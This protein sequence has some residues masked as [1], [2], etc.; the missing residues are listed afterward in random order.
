MA[1]LWERATIGPHG[2]YADRPLPATVATACACAAAWLPAPWWACRGPTEQMNGGRRQGRPPQIQYDYRKF[3][4]GVGRFGA[5][6]RLGLFCI[7]RRR[8]YLHHHL[9][10]AGSLYL[11]APAQCPWTAH[12]ER[13]AIPGQRLHLSPLHDR[14]RFMRAALRRQPTKWYSAL[15]AAVTP[16]TSISGLARVVDG[17]TVVVWAYYW[18][19]HS[20]WGLRWSCLFCI[21]GIGRPKNR[22]KVTG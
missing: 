8:G 1:G 3:Y 22:G 6:R 19:W 21:G 16:V 14:S 7:G 11:P 2:R 17:D 10:G 4:P 13:T 5:R 9:R 15:K 20:S 12:R 18:Q